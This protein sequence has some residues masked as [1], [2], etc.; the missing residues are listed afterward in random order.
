MKKNL[1]D[2]RLFACAEFV[3]NQSVLADIGTDHAYL[4]VSLIL[5]GKIDFALA[6]DINAKPLEKAKETAL[7]YGVEKQVSFRLCDGLNDIK[8]D[9]FSDLAVAGMGGEMIAKILDNC[10]Y[11]KNEKYNLILQPM[12]K[13]NILRKYLCENG[14]EILQEKAVISNRKIY[15]VINARFSGEVRESDLLFEYLGALQNKSDENA[16]AYKKKI[17]KSLVKKAKGIL[18]AD[19]ENEQAKLILETAEKIE[20][21]G[22]EK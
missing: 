19:S 18:S 6:C 12:S 16:I 8:E 22:E 3:R 21:Q 17:K 5:D 20:I 7:K 11:I 15:S 14:F 13:A 2:E 10:P 4:P 9:E 1:L